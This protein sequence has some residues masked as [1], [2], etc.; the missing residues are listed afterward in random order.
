MPHLSI[1]VYEFAALNKEINKLW[2]KTRNQV[3][4][5]VPTLK[6]FPSTNHRVN[7]KSLSVEMVEIKCLVK[8][9]L[10]EGK[11]A[12]TQDFELTPNARGKS[13]EKEKKK[14]H[15][16]QSHSPEKNCSRTTGVFITSVSAATARGRPA[17]SSLHTKEPP[18]PFPPSENTT[19]PFHQRHIHL[20]LNRSL[21]F[22]VLP[23]PEQRQRSL[24]KTFFVC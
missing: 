13:V 4:S 3:F 12:W 7:Y 1:F 14:P 18:C 10:H 20:R 9:H 16:I 21:P 17:S 19:C 23:I 22:F 5:W 6:L 15:S 2:F 11:E 8:G 24:S